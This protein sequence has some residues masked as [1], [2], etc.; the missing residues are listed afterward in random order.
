MTG[1]WRALNTKEVNVIEEGY[2][3]YLKELQ[4]CKEADY[5]VMLEPKLTVKRDVL[6][7]VFFHLF[8]ISPISDYLLFP[9][10]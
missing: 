6:I 8:S 7:F 1:R 5:R 10:C 9:I 2:Q 4:I 3:H